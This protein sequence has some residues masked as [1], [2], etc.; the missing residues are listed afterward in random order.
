MAVANSVLLYATAMCWK[1]SAPK[2]M[3]TMGTSSGSASCRRRTF[4]GW[5]MTTMKKAASGC[6][7]RNDSPST[8]ARGR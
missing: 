4:S 3:S 6:T 1:P 8:R 7:R 2:S 5:S